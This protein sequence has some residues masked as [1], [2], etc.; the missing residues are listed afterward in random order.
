[1]GIEAVSAGAA[2]AELSAAG[3]SEESLQAAS[4]T[5][6]ASAND[7]VLNDMND[8]NDIT[9]SAKQH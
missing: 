5:T 9:F 8:L 6:T 2:A 7:K 1:M 4:A 3:V